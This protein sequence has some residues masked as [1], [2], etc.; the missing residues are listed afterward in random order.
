MTSLKLNTNVVWQF[1][2]INKR[3]RSQSLNRIWLTGLSGSGKSYAC[4]GS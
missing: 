3:H 2:K 4:T 1:Q